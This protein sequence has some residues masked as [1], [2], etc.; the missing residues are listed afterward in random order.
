MAHASTLYSAEGF[1]NGLTGTGSVYLAHMCLRDILE[2]CCDVSRYVLEGLFTTIGLGFGSRGL[3]AVGSIGIES[4]K[5]FS[6]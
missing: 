5:M 3:R 4:R 2:A 6:L 1:F